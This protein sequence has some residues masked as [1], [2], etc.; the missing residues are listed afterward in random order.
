MFVPQSGAPSASAQRRPQRLRRAAATTHSQQRGT[1]APQASSGDRRRVLIHRQSVTPGLIFAPSG[2]HRRKLPRRDES[3]ARMRE[4][5]ISGERNRDVN[6]S[7]SVDIAY[8]FARIRF[9][10][11][12]RGILSSAGDGRVRAKWTQTRSLR[13]ICPENGPGR[14]TLIE[15]ELPVCVRFCHFG[16]LSCDL[17]TRT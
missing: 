2:N 12:K 9:I 6:R 5:L 17:L 16:R 3:D 8:E 15:Q 7:G 11:G 1:S 4:R 13:T 10:N 14:S